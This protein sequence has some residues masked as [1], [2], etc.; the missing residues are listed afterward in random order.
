MFFLSNSP[1]KKL[2]TKIIVLLLLLGVVFLVYSSITK[3][4]V[5]EDRDNIPPAGNISIEGTMVC[6]PHKNTDGPQTL[7]CAYGL[8][9]DSGRYFALRDTDPSY[10]NISGVPFNIKVR[11]EGNFNPEESNVYK[12][13]GIIQ[14]TK[15]IK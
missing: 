11:V 7:E 15:I 1:H 13:I 9:D 3:P 10:G 6:L 5:Q 12:S 14:V 4:N 2:I 8:L